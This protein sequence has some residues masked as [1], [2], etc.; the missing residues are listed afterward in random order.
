MKELER[1]EL[2]GEVVKLKNLYEKNQQTYHEALNLLAEKGLEWCRSLEMENWQN[3]QPY[4]NQ[5][6]RFYRLSP[7]DRKEV[8]AVVKEIAC[9]ML[10][11]V[12]FDYIL[13]MKENIEEDDCK[14]REIVEDAML[15]MAFHIVE[16][17]E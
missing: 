17:E 3:I 7:Y 8:L 15:N 11:N 4:A 9:N 16:D 1:D 2:P 12:L 5:K 13:V 14:E 6:M 10:G